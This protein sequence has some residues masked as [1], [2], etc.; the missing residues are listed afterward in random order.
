MLF[1][2]SSKKSVVPVSD[3]KNLFEQDVAILTDNTRLAKSKV[4]TEIAIFEE[5]KQNLD[6]N[7]T[8]IGDIETLLTIPI[9]DLEKNFEKDLLPSHP[10]LFVELMGY[11]KLVSCYNA[12]TGIE[13]YNKALDLIMHAL[14]ESPGLDV[15]DT[16]YL[17]KTTKQWPPSF[18][19]KDALVGVSMQSTRI[20]DCI[21]SIRDGEDVAAHMKKIQNNHHVTD[22]F[23]AFFDIVRRVHATS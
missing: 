1:G 8:I 20:N 13:S 3:I 17:M 14:V 9:A 12:N 19:G 7:I 22:K 2:T 18:D 16:L 23:K 15:F 6:K 4:A 10:E 11:F 21:N 5:F